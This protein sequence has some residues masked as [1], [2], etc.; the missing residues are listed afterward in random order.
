MFILG[1]D[2]ESELVC[3]TLPVVITAGAAVVFLQLCILTTC[4]LCLYTARRSK[5]PPS[6]VAMSDRQS[7]H[8][9]GS[10]SLSHI[11]LTTCS[12]TVGGAQ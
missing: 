9:C 6:Q 3:T 12:H 8:R 11:T 10:L 5:R 2:R 4:I 1:D 7:L